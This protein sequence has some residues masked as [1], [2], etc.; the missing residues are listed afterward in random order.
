MRE[1][2]K[3]IQQW[4]CGCC[5]QLESTSSSGRRC[6]NPDTMPNGRQGEDATKEEIKQYGAKHK[7]KIVLDRRVPLVGQFDGTI[8]D[9]VDTVLIE[10]LV[11]VVSHIIERSGLNHSTILVD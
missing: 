6:P 5:H 10:I 2:A 9:S 4:I 11:Y 7:A 1:E 8:G 3:Q